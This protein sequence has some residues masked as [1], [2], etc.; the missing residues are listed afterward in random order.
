MRFAIHN[1]EGQL[2]G[3][4]LMTD[5]ESF[6]ECIFRLFPKKSHTSETKDSDMLQR[7]QAIGK[8]KYIILNGLIIIRYTGISES[9]IIEDNLFT[10]DEQQYQLIELNNS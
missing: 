9:I 4:L 5:K 10:V 2:L 6:G 8:L 7:L 1:S 3:F